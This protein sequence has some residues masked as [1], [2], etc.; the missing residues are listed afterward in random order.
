MSRQAISR[1]AL[2]VALAAGSTPAAPGTAALEAARSTVAPEVLRYATQKMVE[3]F[4][5]KEGLA[6]TREL[7]NRYE[8]LFLQVAPYELFIDRFAARLA[9]R[10]TEDELRALAAFQRSLLAAREQVELGFR[11]AETGEGPLYDQLRTQTFIAIARRERALRG[12]VDSSVANAPPLPE[13]EPQPVD[14]ERLQL[15]RKL[16]PAELTRES[17]DRI[18][19]AIVRRMSAELAGHWGGRFGNDAQTAARNLGAFLADSLPYDFI[20]ELAAR[21]L[22]S[23]LTAADLHALIDFRLSPLGRKVTGLSGFMREA[24]AT[25]LSGLFDKERSASVKPPP[26]VSGDLNGL[27][28][29]GRDECREAIAHAATCNRGGSC[30]LLGLDYEN[31]R[32]VALNLLRAHELYE[33]AC[34]EQSNAWACNRLGIAYEGPGGFP[35]ARDLYARGC[36]LGDFS[37]CTNQG[38]LLE[39]GKGGAADQQRANSLYRKACDGGSAAGCTNLGVSAEQGRGM[40]RDP[41]QANALYSKACDAADLTGCVNLGSSL[42]QAGD[43]ARALALFDKACEGG[44]ARGCYRSGLEAAKREDSAR[45][46]KLYSKA[47]DLD[48]ALACT[49]LGALHEKAGDFARAAA[50]YEKGCSKGNGA[51]CANVAQLYREG[52]GVARDAARAN[53]LAR[54]G[55]E[56]GFFRGCLLLVKTAGKPAAAVGAPDSAEAARALLRQAEARAPADALP[57]LRAV[58]EAPVFEQLNAADR[59]QALASAAVAADLLDDVAQALPWLRTAVSMEQATMLDW[60][61]LM[62]SAWDATDRADEVRALTALAHRWPD[63]VWWLND[64]A[65]Y[66]VV[67]DASGEPRR[68]LLDALFRAA[69]K[70]DDGLEPS[71]AWRDLTLLLLERGDERHAAEVA[72]HIARPF[73]LISVHA[74]KRFDAL[75][76]AEPAAFDVDAAVD[77]ELAHAR[78]AYAKAPH[79]LHALND[80]LA[81]LKLTHGFAEMLEL[82]A[83]PPP[84]TDAE[85]G[86]LA[87]TM[88]SRSNAFEGLGRWD[89]AVAELR[90][91]SQRRDHGK[92]NVGQAINLAVLQVALERPREA[93]ASVEELG[94]LSD[95]G[96]ME[97]EL[98][99]HGA[100]LQLGDRAEAARALAYLRARA[101]TG[102]GAL[103][104]ALL[105]QGELAEASKLLVARLQ[106]PL[107]RNDTLANLQIFRGLPETPQ[108]VRLHA[109]RSAL[110][111]RPEVRA[112]LDA[113]GRIIEW[114]LERPPA[115]RAASPGGDRPPRPAP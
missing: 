94:D 100:A 22:A 81:V 56:Q 21:H 69:W 93:L 78:A 33:I 52:R 98:V 20:C 95:Y 67:R 16:V 60:Y 54:R 108:E 106:D 24:S 75:V 8:L 92:P 42:E 79:S 40:D 113:A 58:I 43:T 30:G 47:C 74:D 111:A 36:K 66:R 61:L 49:N 50:L 13:P 72:R 71:S 59:H 12:A 115:L 23:R 34:D 5:A 87:W 2:V 102:A 77:R 1:L 91:A 105:D 89:E 38:R 104:S 68:E 15:A 27:C 45:V 3:S 110:L 4:A 96:R 7:L 17:Y 112:A 107:L 46:T 109:R 83:A 14:Q 65:I 57:A 90:R 25:E 6:V 101:E 29:A 26:H 99:R 41:E 39:Q 63:S 19:R 62:I 53:Q 37:A 73:A 70:E 35:V 32:G 31:G 103:L 48:F 9:T 80:L 82:T 44:N 11:E 10:F 55:C 28:D 18:L 85:A 114:S 88:N 97:V 76:R 86:L 84:E 64:S 51:G